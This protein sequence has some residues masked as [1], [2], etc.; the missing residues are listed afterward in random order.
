V[1]LQ[2][3]F[4][5]FPDGWPGFGL[6]LLRVGMGIAVIWLGIQDFLTVDK[7]P[8]AIAREFVAVIGGIFLIAGFWT[9]ITGTLIAID[10]LWIALSVPSSQGDGQ[11]LRFLLAILAAATAMVGPGAWS[12]DAFRFGRKRFD[13]GKRT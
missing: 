11:W 9:P 1:I 10:E 13:I 2:R 6:L 4:S 5:T 3:L 7:E 8:V 12:I